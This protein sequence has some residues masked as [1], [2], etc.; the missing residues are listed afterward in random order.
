MLSPKIVGERVGLHPVAVIFSVLIFA[1]FLGS[2]GLIIA[3]PT[4]ALIKFLIDE[5]KR[6]EKWKDILGEKTGPS[7]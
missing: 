6:R 4:S 5:W 2:W 7:G 1:R 3:V